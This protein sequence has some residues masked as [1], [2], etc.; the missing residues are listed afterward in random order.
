MRE[1]NGE[2]MA[3]PLGEALRRVREGEAEA[4]AMVYDLYCAPIHNYVCRLLGN[5]AQADDVTQETFLR[6]WQRLGQLRDD[7]RLESWLYTIASHLCTDVVRRRRLLSWLPLGEGHAALPDP[8]LEVGGAL[9]EHEGVQGILGTL[10]PKY[11]MALVLRHVEGFS[12]QEIAEML[13]IS[14]DNVWQRL[15][16]GREMFAAAYERL[17]KGKA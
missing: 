9:A 13:A 12:C 1:G 2:A 6:A 3:V 8:R 11:A 17:G 5:Q 14:V 16:R 10:P 15:S 4:F 7:S